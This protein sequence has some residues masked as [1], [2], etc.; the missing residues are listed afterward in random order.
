MNMTWYV[1]VWNSRS[2]PY[3]VDDGVSVSDV[4]DDG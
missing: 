2:W 1:C 4:C 3:C